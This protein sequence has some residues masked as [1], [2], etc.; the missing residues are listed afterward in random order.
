[1]KFY[2]VL[3]IKELRGFYKY[4]DFNPFES[5]WYDFPLER[6]YQQKMAEYAGEF[7]DLSSAVGAEEW[8]H[9]PHWG[10]LPE[11]H[12]DKD[13]YLYVTTGDL[14]FPICS[15][16]LYIKVEDLIGANLKVG[17][18]II[19]PETNMLVLLNSGVW[20]EITPYESGTRVSIYLNFWD[21]VINTS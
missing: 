18:E 21:R 1:M 10:S 7:A 16:I 11:A 14:E 13:E 15:A 4:K 19:V 20:H 6:Y 9:N 12:Y 3:P 17:E 8:S 2:N 5:K